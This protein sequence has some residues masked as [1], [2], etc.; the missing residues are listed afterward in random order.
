MLSFSFEGFSISVFL[1]GF[2]HS[3]E[4]KPFVVAF[5]ETAFAAESCPFMCVSSWGADPLF[6]EVLGEA[7]SV[8]SEGF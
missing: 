8:E 2:P 4:T 7:M 6:F 5:P 1:E 3:E